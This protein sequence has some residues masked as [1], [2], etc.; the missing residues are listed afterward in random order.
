MVKGKKAEKTVEELEQKKKRKP[1]I[2]DVIPT[3]VIEEPQIEEQPT[4]IEEEES[5]SFK[6]VLDEFKEDGGWVHIKKKVDGKVVKIGKYRPANFDKDEIAKE[7]GG[8]TY[9]YVLR[10]NNGA[11][12]GRSEETY[13]DKK[14]P[15]NKNQNEFMQLAQIIKEQ[16]KEIETLKAEILKPKVENTDDKNMILELIRENQR[17]QVDIFKALSTI[18]KPQQQTSSMT[19]MLTAITTIMTLINKQQPQQQPQEQKSNISDLVELAGMF[20]E[21]KANGDVPK[22][23]TMVDVIK[24]FLTDGSLANVIAIL[25][26]PKQPLIPNPNDNK[27]LPQGQG[28]QGQQGQQIQQPTNEKE[29]MQTVFKQY[30]KQLFQMKVNGNN[31]EYIA[32]TILSAFD[33]DE[34]FKKIGYTYFKDKEQAYNG[35]FEVATEFKNEQQTLR[36]IVE[37][38]HNYFDYD[39]KSATEGEIEN[40][41]QGQ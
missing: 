9:Y 28:Q 8:G 18:N 32:T 15:E 4:E 38:I 12:R 1:K 10:D 11:I 35:L 3:E 31:S 23:E 20:A 25:K 34:N 5:E 40:G 17:Q 2:Q 19:E 37:I 26:Q 41:Q 14:E 36:E 30:E 21:M 13:I 33:F 27:Q 22:Q 6:K 7:F 39:G 29:V 16:T 24:S